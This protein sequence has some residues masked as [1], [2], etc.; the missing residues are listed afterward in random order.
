MSFSLTGR[1]GDTPERIAARRKHGAV[2]SRRSRRERSR[3]APSPTSDP[4]PAV[5]RRVVD[6][7]RLEDHL[8]AVLDQHQAELREAERQMVEEAK[9]KWNAGEPRVYVSSGPRR[10]VIGERAT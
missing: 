10:R 2:T 4:S 3:T 9:A 5:P 8:N 1:F 6:P 7:L